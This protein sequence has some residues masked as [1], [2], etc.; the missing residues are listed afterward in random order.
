[1]KQH[2]YYIYI[3]TNK[4]RTKVYVGVTNNLT[5]RLS[6]HEANQGKLGT[7]AGQYYCYNLVYY[8]HF[9][10]IDKAIKREKQIKKWSR[11]K[12]DFLI[13]TI[14]PEWEFLNEKFQ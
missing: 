7:Y 2:N 10:Y 9:K 1:M 3:V 12:K 8:E 4:K 13:G 5:R 6:E 11:K 14:N